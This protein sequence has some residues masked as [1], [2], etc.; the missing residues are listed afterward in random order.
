MEDEGV[1]N[2]EIDQEIIDAW[3]QAAADLGIRVTAPFSLVSKNGEEEV[4]EALVHDF[5]GPKGTLT[6]KIHR[7][8]TESRKREGYYA[9]N[10]ADSYRKY[11]RK[12][13]QETLDDWRWFGDPDQRPSWYMGKPW[14]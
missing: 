7:D 3:N 11:D 10:L 2:R 5:G 9:S 8:L 6:G 13:F 12:L 14:S 4:F 1:L